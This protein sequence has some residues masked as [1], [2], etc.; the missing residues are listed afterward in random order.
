MHTKEIKETLSVISGVFGQQLFLVRSLLKN[1]R[2]CDKQVECRKKICLCWQWI[3]MNAYFI[4]FLPILSF[5]YR[6][7]EHQLDEDNKQMSYSETARLKSLRRYVRKIIDYVR[8][9]LNNNNMLKIGWIHKVAL[10]SWR[11]SCSAGRRGRTKQ[12]S[13]TR[14]KERCS[15]KGKEG[16]E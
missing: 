1:S 11:H 6:E 4:F 12:Q 3:A 8:N 16:N 2:T 7:C 10:L 5:F 13:H 9:I 15:C 14:S